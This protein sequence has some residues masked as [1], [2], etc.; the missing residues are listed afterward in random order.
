MISIFG[1]KAPF[2]TPKPVR[3]IDRILS[4]A[5]NK[6]SIILDSFAG[7]GTTAHAVMKKNKEDKGQ[8][9]FILVELMDYAESI[10]AER[11][12]RVIKGY[13]GEKKQL[14]AWVVLSITTN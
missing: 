10:T 11:I 2:D 9:K 3:F 7:S 1:G 6:D 5:T 13:G 14:K 12:R 4:I 8:R